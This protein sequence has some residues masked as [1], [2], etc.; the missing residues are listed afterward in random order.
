MI[1]HNDL[2][3]L[4]NIIYIIAEEERNNTRNYLLLNPEDKKRQTEMYRTLGTLYQVQSM[5][6]DL[7]RVEQTVNR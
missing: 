4:D 6:H 1:N 2:L 3:E 7:Y 5:I